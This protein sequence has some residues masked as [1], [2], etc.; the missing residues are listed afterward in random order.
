MVILFLKIFKNFKSSQAHTKSIIFFNILKCVN[1]KH[2]VKLILFIY[3][4][5]LM[6]CMDKEDVLRNN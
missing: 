5:I 4:H 1:L 6:R 2:N 3:L